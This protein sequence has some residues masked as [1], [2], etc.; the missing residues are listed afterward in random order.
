MEQIKCKTCFDTKDLTE[1]FW[2]RN[3]KNDNGFSNSCKDCDQRYYHNYRQYK[4]GKQPIKKEQEQISSYDIKCMKDKAKYILSSKPE[5][6]I[7]Q[8]M[9]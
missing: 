1:E 7:Y 2:Y 5:M 4:G 8:V 6:S 3:A 9:V